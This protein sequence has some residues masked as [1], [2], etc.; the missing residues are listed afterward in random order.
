MPN[1]KP[2]LLSMAILA[3]GAISL[4]TYAQDASSTEDAEDALEEV[5][6]TGFRQSLVNALDKKRASD[7]VTEQLS[8]DDLGGLPDVSMADALTRLPGI[9]AVR[10]G[11][12]AAE[13]NIRGMSGGFVFSTLNGRE[14]V[15]TS[16][17][18]SIEFDQY[19]SELI[20]SAAVYKSPKASLIEGAV[21]GMVELSTANPLERTQQH[22]FNANVRSMYN[23]RAGEISDAV[24]FG[25]RLS[26]SYQGK[27]ADDTLGIALG[28][29]RLYQP[30]VSTQFAGLAYNS[31][32]DLDQIEGDIDGPDSAPEGEFVSEGIELQH[33][34]GE[35]TRDGFMASVQWEPVE[36]FS[37]KADAFLST[38]DT[39][40][41]ARGFRVKFEPTKASFANTDIRENFMVG[42][43]INRVTDGETRVEIVNDDNTDYDEVQSY[44]VNA[45]WQVTEALNVKLDV[46]LS[47]ASSDF[48]NG[49]LWSLVAEDAN[50]DVPVFDNNVSINYQLN[51]LS[52]PDIGL[53]QADYFTDIN[54]VMVSKYGIY[55]FVNTDEVNA[56]KLDVKYDFDLPVL[57]SIEAGVRISSR[58]YT[59]DRSVFEYGADND[60]LTSEPPLKL[61]EDMVEVVDWEGDFSYFPSYLAVDV[62]KALN[63]W[64]PNGV[65]QPVQS[66]GSGAL[67]VIN[68]APG[69]TVSHTWAVLQSGSVFEDTLAGYVMVNLDTEVAGIPVTGNIGVRA[70]KTEQYATSLANVGGDALAGAQYV[71]DEEGY[72]NENYA[73][74]IQG[75][76]YTD[77]LPQMNLNFAITDNDQIRFAAAKVMSRPPINRLASDASL[78]F[79]DT[80]V[81][82]GN[83]SNSP[84]LKSFYADQL[85]LSYEHYFEESDGAVAVALF[86]KDIESTGIVTETLPQ[87]DFAGAGFNVPETYVDETSGEPKAYKN[88]DYE[89]AYNDQDGGYIQGVEFA[90]TQVF[91]MLPKPLDGLGVNLSYSYTESEI[92]KQRVL[93]VSEVK[94]TLEGL[95]KN[96]IST[97][98]FYSFKDFETRIS[99][100]SRD[101]FVSDQVAV[102]SQTVYFA[103]ETVVDYQASY[104]VTDN[105]GIVFQINNLTDEPTRSYFNTEDQTGTIQYFGRQFFMGVTYSM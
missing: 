26:F 14:Q 38:F 63:A 45:D 47:R 100:R 49:L 74:S 54:K 84:A 56:T 80:G 91:S 16:G 33:R 51:G 57:A 60:F 12:Q 46:S 13:I 15:S 89:V 88:G 32:V 48:R 76:E 90:Y 92:E 82:S 94:Q 4:P 19:P 59:N 21:A 20:S 1:F 81:I 102:E 43:T 87:F 36:N 64:F 53:N 27:F 44:G 23:D 11:G 7:M 3:F 10:T 65:P 9:S 6:V 69:S 22:T 55:P 83:A 30:S 70:V 25:H 72:I 104:N 68:P 40:A 97:S 99:V 18:R 105:L 41:F 31:A 2:N 8:A 73:P 86:Y 37:L 96:V 29:A 103:G 85:D 62:D 50:A 5:V 101:K 66:W 34:G 79:S 75:I 98:V 93:G 77:Y 95:S 61:T 28:Y 17:S 24:E 58:E 39:E 78:Y 67:G 35:E 71:E 42:G 52:L